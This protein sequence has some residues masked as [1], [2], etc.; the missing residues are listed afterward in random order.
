[1]RE[2][3]PW[4]SS[5]LRLWASNAGAPAETLVRELDPPSTT[6][7]DLTCQKEELMCHN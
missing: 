6:T 2:G 4:W 1:M 7:K 3:V 5:G